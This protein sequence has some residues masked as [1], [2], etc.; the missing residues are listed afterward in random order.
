MAFLANDPN[1]PSNSW[2]KNS[3]V[4]TPDTYVQI[5]TLEQLGGIIAKGRTG[6]S[7]KPNQLTQNA[8]FRKL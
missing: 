7:I 6:N 3:P 8:I 4:E 1:R 2:M 5:P